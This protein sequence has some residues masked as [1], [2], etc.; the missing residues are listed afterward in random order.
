MD[1]RAC[2]SKT[3]AALSTNRGPGSRGSVAQHTGELGPDWAI[4]ELLVFGLPRA[5]WLPR[6]VGLQAE[7]G[8]GW[9][10]MGPVPNAARIRVWGNVA[11]DRHGAAV[12]FRKRG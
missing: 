4:S 7:A 2:A 10:R 11:V 12:E 1:C 5:E 6:G 3:Y 9:V 8:E